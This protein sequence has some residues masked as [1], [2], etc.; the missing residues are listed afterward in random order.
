[1]CDAILVGQRRVPSV[2]VLPASAGY[3]LRTIEP[4]CANT[5]WNRTWS[6]PN[7]P[8]GLVSVEALKDQFNVNSTKDHLLLGSPPLRCQLSQAAEDV[9]RCGRDVGNFEGHGRPQR[10]VS[11]AK[12]LDLDM[13]DVRLNEPVS[14]GHRGNNP[15][16]QYLGRASRLGPDSRRVETP[17]LAGLKSRERDVNE[18]VSDYVVAS[19]VTQ[20][21][22]ASRS[23]RGTLAFM[24]KKPLLQ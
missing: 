7:H 18:R 16:S 9:E 22:K 4:G 10:F 15:D 6:R 5:S 12:N 14:S 19:T 13:R 8:G 1:M 3:D 24:Q 20:S 21:R 17:Y 11:G 2:L 23:F